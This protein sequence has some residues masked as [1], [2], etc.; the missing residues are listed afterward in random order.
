MIAVFNSNRS[1]IFEDFFF[2]GG[3]AQLL[4]WGLAAN[5]WVFVLEL[6]FVLNRTPALLFV[7]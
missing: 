4:L 6:A 3:E 5:Y 2:L 1:R 7:S